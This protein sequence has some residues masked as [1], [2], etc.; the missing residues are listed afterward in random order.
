MIKKGQIYI[1]VKQHSC[2]RLQWSYGD[3]IEI[4]Y[5]ITGIIFDLKERNYDCKI[6][7][8]A[9][10]KFV[11]YLDSQP[12]KMQVFKKFDSDGNGILSRNE[13]LKLIKSC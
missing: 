4:L 8:N 5:D 3:S 1:C 7:V 10:N 9:L 6:V 11:A 13:F 12:N 2:E